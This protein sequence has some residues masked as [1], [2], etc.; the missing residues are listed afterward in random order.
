[1][2]DEAEDSNQV[3]DARP[4]MHVPFLDLRAVY[5]ELAAP[6]DDAYARVAASG[7]F[8]LGPEL[9]EFER[10]FAAYCGARHCVGVGN[11][12][13]ALH[14]ALRAAGIRPGDEVIVPSNTFIA[15]WLAVTY[16]GA[17]PVPVEPDRR[18]YNIDPAVI[19]SA[20]TP[21]T[22]AIVPVHL[23]GQTA[24]MDQIQFVADRH[25]L[26]I[27]EDAAQAH[28]A[29]YRS[30]KAGTFGSAAAFSF[31]PGKNLGALGDGG[32][33]VTNDDEI[34]DSLRLLR[35]YGSRVKYQ[36]DGLGFNTRLDPLQ[37][38][39]LRAK[40]EVLDDWNDR[41]RAIAARYISGLTG[42]ADVI[43]PVT[44]DGCEP[45]WHLFVI[46]HPRRD[47]LQRYL[48]DRGIDTLIHYPVPPYLSG[49][50]A[51]LGLTR[52]SFP[53]A[54]EI[55]DTVLSLPMGPHLN[56]AQA[57]YVIDCVREFANA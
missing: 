37:A 26:A 45:V 2:M 10:D 42:I 47:A 50:Y 43:V 38:A 56:D 4:A 51:A 17:T 16:A 18:S 31:Y 32:A 44:A 36:H 52:G 57:D 40:L 6:L 9:Q 55:A 1:M 5:A 12:L 29:G 8:I 48:G 7:W 28:G 46:R 22:R 30:A 19:E 11:G 49:A 33:V 20:I 54:E 24:A 35:N 41:R 14:L 21:R 25:G 27:I 39:F 3:I 13:D 53:I 23:Y 15:T 34:A